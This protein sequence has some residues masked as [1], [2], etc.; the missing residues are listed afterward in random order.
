MEARCPVF[1][2]SQMPQKMQSSNQMEGA[3]SSSSSLKC[4]TT[5]CIINHIISETWQVIKLVLKNREHTPVKEELQKAILS[6]L[7]YGLCMRQ[8]TCIYKKILIGAWSCQTLHILNEKIVSCLIKKRREIKNIS[9][10]LGWATLVIFLVSSSWQCNLPQQEHLKLN[11]LS[12]V[13]FNK[14]SY[15]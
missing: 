8:R 3:C 9:I 5:D 7:S 13:F 11:A 1:P 12:S 14:H 6:C 4:P 10:F 15:C 2:E